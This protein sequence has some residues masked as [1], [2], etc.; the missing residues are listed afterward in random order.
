M[1]KVI[2]IILIVA[3]CFALTLAATACGDSGSGG[4]GGDVV[5]GDAAQPVITA[6]P[7]DL[8][9]RKN[10]STKGLEVKAYSDDGGSLSYKWYTN[11]SE[12]NTGGTPIDGETSS[13]LEI[14][15]STT[16]TAYYYCVVTNTNEFVSGNKTASVI[17]EA[18]RVKVY[19][20]TEAP[21]INL[22]PEGAD[23]VIGAQ[24]QAAAANSL[25]SGSARNRVN[26]KSRLKFRTLR[27]A[28]LFPTFRNA[29]IHIISANL[30]I[31]T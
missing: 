31:L 22:Q 1:K 16:Y 15:T 10:E 20:E 14:D 8:L 27:K 17:T 13:I 3:L 30:R 4:S 25:I 18:A 12:S 26:T 11:T 9:L 19:S 7:F 21:R 24:L 28:S 2:S 29:E 23:Y 6:Q 5:K